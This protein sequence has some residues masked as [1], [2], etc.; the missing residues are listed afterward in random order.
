MAKQLINTGTVANDGTG[1]GLRTA[2]T[3]VNSNFTELYSQ[4]ANSW[5]SPQTSNSYN[6]IQVSG[7]TRV[8]LPTPNT[9]TLNAISNRTGTAYE[10][11]ILKNPTSNA[12]LQPIWDN[13]IDTSNFTIFINGNS[14]DG[15]I[16]TQNSNEWVLLY[17]TGGPVSY[18][19]NVTNVDVSITYTAEPQPWFDPVALGYTNFRGAKLDYHA[20]VDNI[21]GFN[22]VGTVTYVAADDYYNT[23]DNGY[24]GSNSTQN[25]DLDVR[26]N[27]DKLHYRNNSAPAGNL[28][29]Q[30]SGVVFTGRDRQ[31]T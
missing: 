6:V 5:V 14:S 28:H 26:K 9:A 27:T 2:F 8:T 1:D 15:F 4:T 12:I 20:Y 23:N 21:Q 13:I 31:V 17:D 29:I 24:N 11:Y 7:A 25:V 18:T 22:R 19:A 30:W 3:K 10:I 16:T